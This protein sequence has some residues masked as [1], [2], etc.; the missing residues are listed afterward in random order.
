MIPNS[1]FDHPD[2]YPW[3]L[4]DQSANTLG[5]SFFVKVV[6]LVEGTT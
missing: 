5:L 4:C 6:S 3:P 1:A 2:P